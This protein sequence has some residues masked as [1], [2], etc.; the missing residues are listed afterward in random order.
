M[1]SFETQ[2]TIQRPV[3]DVFAFVSDWSNTPLWQ[4]GVVK[5]TALTSGPARVG[6]TFDEDVKI[7]IFHIATR[8]VIT[9]LEPDR[10]LTFEA[11]S[12]PIDYQAEFRFEPAP[13]GTSLHIRGTGELR[14]L[15]RIL[16]PMFQADAQRSIEEEMKSIKGHLESEVRA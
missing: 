16:L 4:S 1:L 15:W 2:I 12:S 5:S 13:G 11:S 10:S 14:G 3:P 9:A 6:T 7:A 8:C